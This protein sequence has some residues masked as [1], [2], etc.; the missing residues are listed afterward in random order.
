M[1]K[2]HCLI[3]FLSFLVFTCDYSWSSPWDDEELTIKFYNTLSTDLRTWTN[4]RID[5]ANDM[6]KANDCN[7]KLIKPATHE[8]VAALPDIFYYGGTND[9][10]ESVFEAYMTTDKNKFFIVEEIWV[11]QDGTYFQARG[12]TLTTDDTPPKCLSWLSHANTYEIT[13]A[14]EV[15][16]Q[17]ELGYGPDGN[18]MYPYAH[19]DDTGMTAT[20]ISTLE[21]YFEDEE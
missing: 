1:K 3:C 19:D 4:D 13:L 16:Q 9:N 10:Y 21:A 7:C 14:H 2:I 15:G 20:Q 6:F 5:F 11:D 17:A 18:F 8:V 12:L